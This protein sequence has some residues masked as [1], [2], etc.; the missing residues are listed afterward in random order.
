MSENSSIVKHLFIN[1]LFFL[2]LALCKD[3]R[4]NALNTCLEN[5]GGSPSD[6]ITDVD[7]NN[8]RTLGGIRNSQ[9]N[10]KGDGYPCWTTDPLGG[11]IREGRGGGHYDLAFWNQDKV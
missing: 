2:P 8:C 3:R 4:P 10:S 11:F 1:V 5:W 6:L 7:N 9:I